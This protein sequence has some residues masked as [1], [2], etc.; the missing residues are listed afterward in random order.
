MLEF[1]CIKDSD[2]KMSAGLS[3][4]GEQQMFHFIVSL[5]GHYLSDFTNN[6]HC[7]LNC[8]ILHL[9]TGSTGVFCRK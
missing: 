1:L 4:P 6:S 8:L 5:F 7:S 9:A 2:L 3:A